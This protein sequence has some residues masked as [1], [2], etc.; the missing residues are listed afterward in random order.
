MKTNR[1]NQFI[2]K[3]IAALGHTPHKRRGWS[4]LDFGSYDAQSDKLLTRIR[5]RTSREKRHLLTDLIAQSQPL[6]LKVIISKDPVSVTQGIIKI[7]QEKQP[8]WGRSKQVVAW[9]HPLIESLGL[10]SALK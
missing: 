2:G 6:N 8:E 1:K 7:I 4:A 5:N 3:V 10:E 9:K